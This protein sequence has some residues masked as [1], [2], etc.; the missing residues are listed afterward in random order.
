MSLSNR[1]L[2]SISF[3]LNGLNEQQEYC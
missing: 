1:S 2:L 3:D